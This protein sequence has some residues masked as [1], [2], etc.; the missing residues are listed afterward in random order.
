[1]LDGK[2]AEEVWGQVKRFIGKAQA[3]D[4]HP[5]DGWC[6]LTSVISG[7]M[8]GVEHLSPGLARGEDLIILVSP[9]KED[10]HESDNG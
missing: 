10:Q 9:T 6:N 7:C 1:M 2:I 4:D 5:F 8:G 3:I